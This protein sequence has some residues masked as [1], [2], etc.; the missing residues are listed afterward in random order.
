MNVR[1]RKASIKAM[2][3]TEHGDEILVNYGRGCRYNDGAQHSTNNRKY[4]VRSL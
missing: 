2:R 3:D 1:N 4:D